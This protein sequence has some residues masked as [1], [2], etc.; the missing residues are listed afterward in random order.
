MGTIVWYRFKSFFKNRTL[1]FWTLLFPVVLTTIFY[2]VFS[3]MQFYTTVDVV[4]VA[5][6]DQGNERFGKMIDELANPKKDYYLLDAKTM[7]LSKARKALDEG[8]VKAVIILSDT[9]KMECIS[10]DYDTTIV[11]T[12][13][14]TYQR[15]YAQA[16]HIAKDNPSQLAQF[17][18]NDVT[19]ADMN[20]EIV[21]TGSA[22]KEEN[23]IYFYSALALMCMYGGLWGNKIANDIQADQSHVAAR[24][25]VAPIA[26]R[27]FLL[28]DFMLG[29]LIMAVEMGLLLLYMILILGVSFGSQLGLVVL[30]CFGGIFL[31]LSVG[32]LIGSTHLSWSTKVG[33]ISGFSTIMNTFAG[34]VGN[35][36]PYYVDHYLPIMRYINPGSLLTRS[37]SILYYYENI[38]PVYLNIA[39]LFGAGAVL[40][41]LLYRKIRRESYAS[42]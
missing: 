13:L 19:H 26:K 28:I 5:V 35:A 17:V 1:M 8:K 16:E 34:M 7:S 37:F 21:K 18:K 40:F 24:M 42:I 4:P 14:N 22:D 29:F 10:M 30:V 12:V 3:D 20:V 33:L 39:I 9:P 38:Q 15:I 23:V 25:N 36:V 2:F 27:N 41:L 6:V 31:M 32:I 11:K